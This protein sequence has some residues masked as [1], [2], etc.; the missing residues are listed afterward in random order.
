MPDVNKTLPIDHPQSAQKD[1]ILNHSKSA[2]S[3]HAC[4]FEAGLFKIKISWG[5]YIVKIRDLMVHLLRYHTNQPIIKLAGQFTQHQSGA[6][7]PFCL[8][9][10]GEPEQD[11]LTFSNHQNDSFRSS[12]E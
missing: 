1:I 4:Q 10:L 5:D 11:N 6:E 12:K 7:L 3:Y 8:V 2:D 9:R